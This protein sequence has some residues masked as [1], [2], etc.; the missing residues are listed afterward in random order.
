[1]I[2]NFFIHIM[3]RTGPECLDQGTIISFNEL[4]VGY[5]SFPSVKSNVFT[6][7]RVLE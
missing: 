5:L 2:D 3:V 1:M 6:Y 7:M 4:C